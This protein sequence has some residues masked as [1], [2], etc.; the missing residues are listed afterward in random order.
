MDARDVLDVLAVLAED[1]V[2]AVLHGGWGIDAVV[3]SQDRDHDDV[4][5][6][7]SQGH[8]SLAVASLSLVGFTVIDDDDAEGGPATVTMVDRCGRRVDLTALRSDDA[9]DQWM[10]DGRAA[11]AFPSSAFTDGW[12]AGRE[13]RC[14]A[15]V[16]Q[17]ELHDGYPPRERDR[18]DMVSLQEKFGILPPPQYR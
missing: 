1:G 5:L 15:A 6:L 9:G 18:H 8:L 14:V 12:V 13:V 17:V 10:G 11:V 7:M 4:D 16:K 2:D 3:G